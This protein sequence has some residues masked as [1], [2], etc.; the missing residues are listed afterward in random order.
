MANTQK[1]DLHKEHKQEYVT[2]KTP[3]LV[4]VG[5]AKYLAIEGEGEPGGEVF[6]AKVKAMYGMAFTIKMT[7]KF[8]WAGLQGLP[9]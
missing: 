8:A 9:P 6:Q 4:E 7:K 3:K 5:P 2:P 1:L